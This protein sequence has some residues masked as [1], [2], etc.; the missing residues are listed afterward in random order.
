ML[1]L[2]REKKKRKQTSYVAQLRTIVTK[3]VC[4]LKDNEKS[5]DF[6]Y[7]MFCCCA[8]LI[9]NELNMW[10]LGGK[11]NKRDYSQLSTIKSKSIFY[12]YF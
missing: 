5:L 3:M 2:R 7:D 6:L 12:F 11:E 1:G 4:P 10:C 9:C 8:E